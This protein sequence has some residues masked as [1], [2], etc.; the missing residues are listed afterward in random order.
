MSTELTIVVTCTDRKAA[1]PLPQHQVRHLPA[2]PGRAARGSVDRHLSQATDG[3]PLR[4]LYRGEAWHQVGRLEEAARSKGF[5][6]EV[7]VVSAGLGLRRI[8]SVAPSYAATFSAGHADSVGKSRAE[9]Q[10]WWEHVSR[11]PSA[12]RLRRPCP[13]PTLLVLS[14]VYASALSA[15]L[16]HCRTATTW[17]SLAAQPALLED[18][19]IPANLGLRKRP[20]RDRGEP[21]RRAWPSPGWTAGRVS[22]CVPPEHRQAWNAWSSEVESTT[23]YDRRAIDDAGL[24]AWIRAASRTMPGLSKTAALR[25][26]RDSGVA[27]EQR[28][29]GATVRPNH[30]GS[31]TDGWIERRAL[32]ILQN[33][34]TLSICSRWPP[35]RSTSSP[36]SPASV[37]TRPAS[38][39]ATSDRRSRSTSSRSRTTSTAPTCCSPTD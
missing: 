37:E 27:C 21:Q 33:D 4:H 13:G 24:H 9:A 23:T 30:G 5:D 7:L 8:D 12:L 10:D 39:S 11:M 32:R 19:R 18:Q 17:S 20:R 6:P 29:F 16:E 31:M 34:D 36:T 14:E 25:M 38:S 2:S 15:D 26:L 28:R 22:T 3:Q 1:S 35:K